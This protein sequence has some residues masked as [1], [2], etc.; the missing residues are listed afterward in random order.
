MKALLLTLGIIYCHTTYG[1]PRLSQTLQ[2]I[3]F[4][5]TKIYMDSM[6]ANT[7]GKGHFNV[8]IGKL[9]LF[10]KDALG[11]TLGYISNSMEYRVINPSHYLRYNNN[12]LLVVLGGNI[13]HEDLRRFDIKKLNEDT[14]TAIVQ[15]LYPSEL[16]FISHHGA[17]LNVEVQKDTIHKGYSGSQLGL[18]PYK[19]IYQPQPFNVEKRTD[20]DKYKK[21][22]ERKNK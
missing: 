5:E 10:E 9:Y 11:F 3:F 22:S 2:E 21:S 14:V 13:L 4:T 17:F 1:Q 20:F 18:P 16:G 6:N 19:R 12:Y 15:K 8:Y 7:V